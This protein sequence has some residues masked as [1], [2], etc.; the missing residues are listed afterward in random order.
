MVHV[1]VENASVTQDGL[2]LIARALLPIALI[3]IIVQD[4]VLVNVINVLVILDSGA[5][6]V[7]VLPALKFP[8]LH[9]TIMVPAIVMAHVH[10]K[11]AG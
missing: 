4:M 1:Y 5:K 10:V 2:A 11:A 9:A 3:K 8:V 6:I 7:V